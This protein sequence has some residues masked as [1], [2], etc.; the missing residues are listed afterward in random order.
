MPGQISVV[1]ALAGLTYAV[2]EGGRHGFGRP[3]V[4]ATLALAAVTAGAMFLPMCALIAGMNMISVKLATRTSPRVPMVIGQLVMGGGAL[5]LLAVGPHAPLLV[6]LLLLVPIGLGGGLAVPS[7]T[8]VLLESVTAEWAGTAAA[9]LNT[10]RQ[11]GSCLAVAF[12]GALI[13]E[14]TTFMHGLH[15]SLIICGAMLA[16]TATATLFLLPKPR[17][18]QD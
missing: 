7:L 8:A 17:A 12:F 5:L 16:A 11:V 9:V 6:P 15:V 1:I 14:R 3:L 2:I 13:A 18:A 10:Y 4:T